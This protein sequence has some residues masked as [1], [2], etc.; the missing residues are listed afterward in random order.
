MDVKVVFAAGKADLSALG[1][2]SDNVR[3]VGFL[4]LSTFLVTAEMAAQPVGSDRAAHRHGAVIPGTFC[5]T[6][7]ALQVLPSRS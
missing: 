3:S 6:S 2:L 1:A 7:S 4:P 5:L